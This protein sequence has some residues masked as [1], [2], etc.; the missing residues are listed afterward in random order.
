MLRQLALAAPLS[1]VALSPAQSLT[2]EEFHRRNLSGWD[3][4]VFKCEMKEGSQF[5]IDLCDDIGNRFSLL[6]ASLPI[7]T[8]NC[9][10]C[11]GVIRYLEINKRGFVFPLTL[12][13]QLSASSE[14]GAAGGQ[15]T[16][17][18]EGDYGDLLC[19]ESY[20]CEGKQSKMADVP[21]WSNY[22]SY[23]G[24]LG[25]SLVDELGDVAETLMRQFLSA[26]VT[27][28]E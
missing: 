28:R 5:L 12:N 24:T 14:I 6:T 1:W 15:V 13:V 9:G 26:Y 2:I 27:A 17:S 10:N 8:I 18:A 4:L 21:V 7:E 22:F 11:E 25:P 20:D 3:V 16:I 19:L 23:N